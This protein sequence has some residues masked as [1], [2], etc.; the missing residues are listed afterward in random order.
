MLPGAWRPGWLMRPPRARSDPSPAS[1]PRALSRSLFQNIPWSEMHLH[2]AAPC[3][4]LAHAFLAPSPTR[5]R[6][7][8]RT[9]SHL[10]GE[11][12]SELSETRVQRQLPIKTIKPPR[13]PFSDWELRAHFQQLM[14]GPFLAGLQG[15]AWRGCLQGVNPFLCSRRKPSHCSCSSCG[16][17]QPGSLQLASCKNIDCRTSGKEKGGIYPLKRLSDRFQ[18]LPHTKSLNFPLYPGTH[19]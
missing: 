14:P 4:G 13:L 16:L 2:A 8:A 6:S 18:N 1:R 12:T 19:T 5:A 3:P 17:W 9:H 7:H 15:G 10:P 11:H